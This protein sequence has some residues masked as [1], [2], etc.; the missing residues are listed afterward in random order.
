[1]PAP[2]T[3]FADHCARGELAYTVDADGRPVWPPRWGLAWRVSAG[4]G[5]VHATT[6]VRRRGEEPHNVALVALDEGFRMMSRVE[7][8]EVAVGMRVEVRFDDAGHPCF[9]PA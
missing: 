8:D 6:T 1:M 7:A 5:E 2:L 4:R 3:T 9:V